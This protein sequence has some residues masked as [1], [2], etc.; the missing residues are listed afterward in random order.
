MEEIR[1]LKGF[2]DFPGGFRLLSDKPLDARYTGETLTFLESIEEA[3]AAYPGL[4]VF[5]ESENSFYVYKK[6]GNGSYKFRKETSQG[7]SFKVDDKLSDTSTNPVENRVIT[8]ALNEKGKTTVTVNSEEVDV[9]DADT[10]LDKDTTTAIPANTDG[11]IYGKDANGQVMVPYSKSGNKVN[12]L[13]MRDGSL[14][15]Q[16][17]GAAAYPY[18]ATANRVITEGWA[19]VRVTKPIKLQDG[20]TSGVIP[21]GGSYARYQDIPVTVALQLM[22]DGELYHQ[23][24]WDETNK[25]KVFRCI[26]NNVIKT[27]TVDYT[28]I[29]NMTWELTTSTIEGE[30]GSVIIECEAQNDTT[31]NTLFPKLSGET[32]VEVYEYTQNGK[33]VI[34]KWLDAN[35]N[36]CFT[37]IEHPL[38]NG[39]AYSFS[40]IITDNLLASYYYMT[41]SNIVINHLK[42]LADSS[43]NTSSIS[44]VQNKVVAAALKEK[45]DSLTAA[46]LSAANSGITSDKVSK[47][48][49]IANDATRTEHTVDNGKIIINGVVYTIYDDTKIRE[50]AEGKCKAYVIDTISQITGTLTDSQEYVNVTA[51]PGV[52]FS[53][54]HIGDVILIKESNVP[55]YWVSEI[56]LENSTIALCKLETTKVDLDKYLEK[57][58]NNTNSLILYGVQANSDAQITIPAEYEATQ[59]SIVKRDV[60]GKACFGYSNPASIPSV[61]AEDP[62]KLRDIVATMGNIRDIIDTTHRKDEVA[63]TLNQGRENSVLKVGDVQARL[64]NSLTM[65]DADIGKV[66]AYTAIRKP[67]ESTTTDSGNQVANVPVQGA[68]AAYSTDTANLRTN[69]PVDFKDAVNLEHLLNPYG[70]NQYIVPTVWYKHEVVIEMVFNSS[71]LGG[72]GIVIVGNYLSHSSNTNNAVLDGSVYS[73]TQDEATG[74]QKFVIP[75]TEAFYAKYVDVQNA[76]INIFG[77]NFNVEF[78]YVGEYDPAANKYFIGGAIIDWFIG[79]VNGFSQESLETSYT[80]F[81]RNQN[82]FSTQRMN[83]YDT[84]GVVNGFVDI[85]TPAYVSTNLHSNAASSGFIAR[86]TDRLKAFP[87]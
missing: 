12:T 74:R 80:M 33:V 31:H 54:L 57:Q 47:L 5:I 16:C 76:F 4:K 36:A 39:V 69:R 85:L 81:F 72:Q 46:Q 6:D 63:L 21:D 53:K 37:Y 30:G 55:D 78:I 73:V 83:T 17:R 10:K 25:I 70:N 35:N 51:I 11:L 60:V 65:A 67:G 1:E 29:G 34:L 61:G 79:G 26:S 75:D 8:N 66:F 49:G 64:R 40:A 27:I 86:I 20:Q 43:L 18:S 56:D 71:T 13:V 19:D 58:T 87:I 45:Q 44:P 2:V 9:F 23:V 62:N 50:I 59:R 7:G 15:I 24:S 28:S 3:G 41:S 82:W 38:F 48:D 77:N 42:S 68:I 14:N 32:M 52:D 84:N 22:L